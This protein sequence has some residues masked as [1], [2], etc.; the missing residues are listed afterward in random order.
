ME[1]HLSTVA[2]MSISDPAPAPPAE[3]PPA[4]APPA[5][6]TP[7]VAEAPMAPPVDAEAPMGGMDDVEPSIPDVIL[8]GKTFKSLADGQYDAIVLS[9]GLKECVLA[10]LL[11]VRGLRVLQID[12]N[13]YYGGQCSSVNL[14]ELFEK[15][16]KP[17]DP[18]TT[19]GTFGRS[20]DYCV[21]AVP[22]LLMANGKL[23]KMLLQTGV[24]RY[25]DFNGIS[26]SYVF[27]TGKIYKLPV[28]A[29]EAI[30][31]S[32]VS[33]FQKNALRKFAD[34]IKNYV[35]PRRITDTLTKVEF[36][37]AVT[38]YYKLHNVEKISD[39]DGLL[40]QFDAKR[41]LLVG[42][43]EQK[44]GLPVLPECVDVIFGAG[45]LCIRIE[46]VPLKKVTQGG[47]VSTVVTVT[48]FI[49]NSEGKPGPAEGKVCVGDIISA[50]NGEAV[51]GLSD[52]ELQQKIVNSPRPLT[53]T[54]V[55]PAFDTSKLK[56]DL[57]KM[58]MRELYQKFGLDESTQNFLGHAMALQTDDSYL[59]KI[60]EPTV[61]ACQLY[62]RSV[63]RY[64]Q[65]SP[66]L[67]PMYGLSSLPE[68]FSRLSAIYGGTVMLRTEVDEILR[69]ASGTAVGVRVGDQ[70]ASA[71]F[72]IGDSSYFPTDM[73]VKVGQVA[74]CIRILRSPIKNT[75][76]DSAQI[77]L[78]AKHLSNKKNDCYV[79]EIGPS[80]RVSP[81]G[82]L[83]GIA[84][85][86][87]ETSNPKAELAQALA[88]MPDYAE[89]FFTV[90]DVFAPTS[91]GVA[92]KCFVVSSLDA[93]SH[94]ESASLDIMRIYK[95]I[96]GKAL[97]LD[98]KLVEDPNQ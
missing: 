48:G 32:L 27:N 72:I 74:R 92:T 90:S 69:D 36:K 40:T 19:E 26:G 41:E 55:K 7:V 94:F 3:A 31:S 76:G 47:P 73:S 38:A 29:S 88:L 1:D 20:R 34:Y 63:G 50:V 82:K 4:E 35:G 39:V 77:I 61:L 17:F 37:D 84:S 58:T 28:T 52:K 13:A 5:Q 83:I 14:K 66:Y 86:T 97:D 57:S 53:I 6:A 60:A 68:G 81:N 54:F 91:D 67:Y 16:N 46:G 49:P 96:M 44:Y 79:S 25:I 22:K 78:P 23:V 51:L 12:R 8:N 2:G 93:E 80:L 87:V 56:Y 33:L 64:G 71:K 65:D 89:E 75:V 10:G 9:T 62:G 30:T 11:S 21:D 18:K 98:E 42:A 70:A 15:H 24:T 95:S 43:L 59:D 45:S 85:T